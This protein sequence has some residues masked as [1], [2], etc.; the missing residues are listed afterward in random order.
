MQTTTN[1]KPVSIKE[2][3]DNLFMQI[4][5]Q[6]LNLQNK[7]VVL[8]DED[9]YAA[10][11]NTPVENQEQANKLTRFVFG[12]IR[13]A[14]K[15]GLVLKI[16]KG[17]YDVTPWY[18]QKCLEQTKHMMELTGFMDNPELAAI[19]DNQLA[20]AMQLIEKYPPFVVN[21]RTRRVTQ[22]TE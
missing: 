1:N 13:K 3:A 21:H 15:T 14:A 6:N 4:V 22:P 17:Y 18:H 5:R 16:G 20:N 7:R 10:I 2:Y 12:I 19:Y 9:L 11:R 8:T